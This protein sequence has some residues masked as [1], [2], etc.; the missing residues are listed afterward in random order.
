MDVEAFGSLYDSYGR[1]CYRVARRVITD[2]QLA[3]DVVQNV[4]LAVWRGDAVFDATRGS[5][6]TW[7]LAITHHKAVDAVR[8]NDRHTRRAATDDALAWLPAQDDVEKEGWQLTRR[9]PSNSRSSLDC[10][11]TWKIRCAAFAR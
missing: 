7:L 9:A 8:Q 5:I 6:R 11:I 1:D 3:E 10:S 4:F 2:P